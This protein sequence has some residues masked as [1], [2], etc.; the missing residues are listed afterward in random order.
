MQSATIN[1]TCNCKCARESST[2][3]QI[4]LW[5]GLWLFDQAGRVLDAKEIIDVA[6]PLLLK[7]YELKEA[8]HAW[9]KANCEAAGVPYCDVLGLVNLFT[10]NWPFFNLLTS[11]VF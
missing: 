10:P 2:S 7:A 6:P 3:T 1:A 8:W 9:N 4:N 5:F 11:P